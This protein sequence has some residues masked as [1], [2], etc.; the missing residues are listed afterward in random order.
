MSVIT[1]GTS[2]KPATLLNGTALLQ[3]EQGGQTLLQPTLH[4][5]GPE[6]TTNSG[7]CCLMKDAVPTSQ[8]RCSRAS[9]NLVLVWLVE[10]LLKA[11]DWC[12]FVSCFPLL[13]NFKL[14]VPGVKYA[15]QASGPSFDFFPPLLP[16]T[17]STC[18][19]PFVHFSVP[20]P[21]LYFTVFGC[22][23]SKDTH[24]AGHLTWTRPM[25]WPTPFLPTAP[26]YLW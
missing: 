25:R 8:L 19:L 2:S 1:V 23:T 7:R 6:E 14:A 20:P 10:R 5:T 22:P 17:G 12:S 16:H 4:G 26:A 18:P 3:S 24:K 15:I 21:P 11:A 13:N 9:S